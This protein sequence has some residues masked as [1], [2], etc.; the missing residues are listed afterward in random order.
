MLP[1]ECVSSPI[2]DFWASLRGTSSIGWSLSTSFL[3]FHLQPAPTMSTHSPCRPCLVF[4]SPGGGN[5]MQEY[6][7]NAAILK[8]D[9]IWSPGGR[10]GTV[11]RRSLLYLQI[12]ATFPSW[13]AQMTRSQSKPQCFL[14]QRQ[15]VS[16]IQGSRFSDIITSIINMSVRTTSSMQRD[17]WGT[18]DMG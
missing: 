9:N 1:A 16:S 8:D 12:T 13:W 10:S 18:N 2:S 14:T 5:T 4:M 7:K 3:V 6:G 17:A 15:N 11:K